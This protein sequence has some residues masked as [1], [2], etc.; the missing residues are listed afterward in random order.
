MQYKVHNSPNY[1]VEG[2]FID[3]EF[4][5]EQPGDGVREGIKDLEAEQDNH[6]LQQER[7]EISGGI[8]K[9]FTC[10]RCRRHNHAVQV[11]NAERHVSRHGV[12]YSP[13]RSYADCCLAI[14]RILAKLETD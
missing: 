8:D 1:V 13:P 11:L 7:N 10:E 14:R 12:P 9:I 4:G 3:K 6:R 2:G 5:I